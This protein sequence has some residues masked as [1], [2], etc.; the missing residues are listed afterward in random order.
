MFCKVND[1][2]SEKK[3]SFLYDIYLF[4]KQENSC[5][6]VELLIVVLEKINN[7]IQYHDYEKSKKVK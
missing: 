2:K 6:K 5:L 7:Y 1:K 4:Q 3:N